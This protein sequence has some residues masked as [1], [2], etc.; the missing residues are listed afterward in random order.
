MNDD[1]AADANASPI[2]NPPPELDGVVPRIEDLDHDIRQ[3]LIEIEQV[4]Q[5]SPVGLVLMDMNYRFVR[6]NVS[7]G[8]PPHGFRCPNRGYY[9]RGVGDLAGPRSVPVPWQ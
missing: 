1:P 8:D 2:E 5:H 9:L 7:V 3:E 6:I 4:Y